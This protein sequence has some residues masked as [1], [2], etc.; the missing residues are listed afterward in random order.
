MS[1][2]IVDKDLKALRNGRWDKAFKKEHLSNNDNKRDAVNR[3]ATIVIEH[4]IQ[5]SDI[6]HTM[7]HWQVYRKWVSLQSLLHKVEG[8]FRLMWM[9][10]RSCFSLS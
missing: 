5:A 7:Q 3:K 10:R 8:S 1:T 9:L 4:I 6:S 2:D